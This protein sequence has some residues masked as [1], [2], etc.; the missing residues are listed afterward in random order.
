MKKI[1]WQ[2]LS[3]ADRELIV[4]AREIRQRAYAP[5]SNYCVGAALRDGQGHIHTGCN[6]ES[7]DM[8]LTTH[9]EMMAVDTMVKSGVQRLDAIAIV[10][11]AE[12]GYG[13]PCGL[14]R[15]KIRE[16][17]PGR[18]VRILGVNLDENEDV[19][20]IFLTSLHEI[21]PYSFGSDC[22]T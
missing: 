15:Q 8:T 7:V 14:C 11:Q 10:L 17:A 13:M 9:A 20:D 12:N 16:F 21:L 1:E 2:D 6:V 5:Y 18:D 4:A 19:R 3:T 22:L